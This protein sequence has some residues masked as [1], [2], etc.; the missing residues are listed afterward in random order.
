MKTPDLSRLLKLA[1]ESFSAVAV[2]SGTA[3]VLMTVQRQLI[4]EGV[5]AMLF[6]LAVA[7]SAYHWGLSGGMSAALSAALLFDFL[8]IPP[9]FTFNVA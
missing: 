6:L 9:F 3:F 4:G 8:F 7:W 5:I 2:I 1:R